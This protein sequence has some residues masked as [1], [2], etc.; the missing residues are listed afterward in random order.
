MKKFIV[1]RYDALKVGRTHGFGVLLDAVLNE[2]HKLN[3]IIKAYPGILYET[4]W[5]GENVLHWLA[6]ENKYEE[7]RLLR[8]FGSPIPRFAL[9]HAVEM[10]HLETVITLLELGA[11]VVPEEIQ[12]A[13]KCS[14]YDTSK[15]KTAI[16]RSYFSQFG[17]EV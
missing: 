15:R 13:I 3:D 11:E 14:Y 17:Y 16:L 6:V 5:A 10:R 7:I 4:C 9:V 1:P 8:K 2:P 12:R